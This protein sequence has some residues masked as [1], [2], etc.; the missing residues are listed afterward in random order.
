MELNALTDRGTSDAYS[1]RFG[2]PASATL[3]LAPELFPVA[4]IGD[5][6]ELLYHQGWRRW[7]A[8]TQQG[9]VAAQFSSIS[10][11]VPDAAQVLTIVEGIF[12]SSGGAATDFNADFGYGPGNV[13]LATVLLAEFR[14]G[15]QRPSG[16][17]QT[18]ISRG[19]LVAS[20]ASLAFQL[21]SP[22]NTPFTVPGAP[23]VLVPGNAMSLT[24][25]TANAAMDFCVVYRERKLQDQENVP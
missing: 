6:P 21:S 15:R 14:D 10:I 24:C 25:L 23:W 13:D 4:S 8:G 9:A 19:T 5:Y 7:Q 22:A 17:S 2:L 20:P 1:R 11:R 3:S 18:I 12:L 16:N